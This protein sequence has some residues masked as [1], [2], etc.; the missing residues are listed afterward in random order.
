MLEEYSTYWSCNIIKGQLIKKKCLF[1]WA[2]CDSFV[3][4]HMG[5]NATQMRKF[6]TNNLN[7]K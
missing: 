6:K 5:L 3:L 1:V 4:I 2:T 7:P